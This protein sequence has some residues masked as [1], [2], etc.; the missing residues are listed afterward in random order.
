[1][2]KW[3]EK[4]K[5][6]AKIPPFGIFLKECL[7]ISNLL[8]YDFWCNKN[9]K[10]ILIEIYSIS[11]CFSHL[12][13]IL[14]WYNN[15]HHVFILSE[16]LKF[17]VCFCSRC[18]SLD[19]VFFLN[20]RKKP[21]SIVKRKRTSKGIIFE[22]HSLIKIQRNTISL[23]FHLVYDHLHIFTNSFLIILEMLAFT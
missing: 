18:K 15:F 23:G 2:L 12:K 6:Q 1:M 17:C 10:K 22:I 3:H 5:Q 19:C 20:I 4:K 21:D 14:K 13:C 8:W 7:C 16:K 11:E 9:K